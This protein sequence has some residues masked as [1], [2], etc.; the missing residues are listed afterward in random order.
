[1]KVDLQWGWYSLMSFLIYWS[2]AID[3]RGKLDLQLDW[4]LRNGKVIHK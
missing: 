1:M 2:K 4:F 3:F